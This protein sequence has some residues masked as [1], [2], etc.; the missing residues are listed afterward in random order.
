M[1][2]STISLNDGSVKSQELIIGNTVTD[3]PGYYFLEEIDEND[4]IIYPIEFISTF[5]YKLGEKEYSGLAAF[6]NYEEKILCVPLTPYCNEHKGWNTKISLKE[7]VNY[8]TYVAT[9]K[10]LGKDENTLI[11][12]YKSIKKHPARNLKGIYNKIIKDF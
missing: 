10:A 7:L 3:K 9:C 5:K 2:V 6:Y 11:D 8:G 12:Y 4:Y 1:K